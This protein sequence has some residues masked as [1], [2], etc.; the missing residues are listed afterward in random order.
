MEYPTLFSEELNVLRMVGPPTT[1]EDLHFLREQIDKCYNN[2][3]NDTEDLFD[4]IMLI[5]MYIET[6]L[7]DQPPPEQEFI[8]Q[9]F[10][11]RKYALNFMKKK[12]KILKDPQ[13][14]YFR[15]EF[16]KKTQEYVEPM[17]RI[18]QVDLKIKK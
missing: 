7:I 17:L 18:Y 5:D 8:L 1:E 11:E 6:C 12:G 15:Q 4:M 14:H 13:L 16:R 3:N 10:R 9:L 2:E